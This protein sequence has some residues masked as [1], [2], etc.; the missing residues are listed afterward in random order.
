MPG[1]S[2]RWRKGGHVLRPETDVLRFEVADIN[3][4]VQRAAADAD[5][6]PDIQV[7]AGHAPD[8]QV[9]VMS[10]FAVVDEWTP[11]RLAEGTGF[12]RYRAARA[13][14]LLSAGFDLGPPEVFI[15]DVPDPRNPVHY[16]L[17]IAAGSNLVPDAIFTGTPS[18]RR[19]ARA[20]LLPTFQPALDLLG[21]PVDLG[22][23]PAVDEGQVR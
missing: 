12:L 11:A 22:P 20:A 6:Y 21:P 5:L 14:V 15:D 2:V 10:C 13:E 23:G 4:V 9:L 18:E 19:T 3:R 7:A 8:W 1:P 17:V 16:D